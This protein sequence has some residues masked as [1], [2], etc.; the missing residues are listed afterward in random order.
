MSLQLDLALDAWNKGNAPD[1]ICHLTELFMQLEG[2]DHF[3]PLPMGIR[4]AD[5]ILE[6]IGLSLLPAGK[7][8]APKAL[9][10]DIIIATYLYA[11]G[12]HTALAGDLAATLSPPPMA[13]WLTMCHPWGVQGLQPGAIERTGLAKVTRSFDGSDPW[14]CAN[15]LVASIAELRPARIFLIHHPHDCAAVIAAA[16]AKAMGSS[17]LLLHHAD[18]RPTL[19]LYLSGIQIVD[20]TPR[21]AWFAKNIMGLSSS[22]IPLTCHDPGR[23][24]IDFLSSGSLTTGLCGND[25]KVSAMIH[26]AYPELIADILSV[27]RGIHVHVGQL[28]VRF[29]K[30]I[31][32]SLS[33]KNLEKERFVWVERTESLVEEMRR[34]RIDLMVNTYPGGGAR[35]AVEVMAAGIPMI[36]HSPF[37]ELD[38]LRAQMKYPSAHIWHTIEDLKG[39]LRRADKAWLERQGESARLWYEQQHHIGNWK[40]FFNGEGHLR[41][42]EIPGVFNA[43]A[44]MREVLEYTL[45]KKAESQSGR[46]ANP[47]VVNSF[48]TGVRRLCDI[49]LRKL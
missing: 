34:H 10:G 5:A 27:T 24:K 45:E 6:R 48:R 46:S 21:A 38:V 4:E 11:I 30:A 7:R 36:W 44:A 49:I 8:D 29:R 20:F 25:R 14:I 47:G 3:P 26:P 39:I 22:Y 17:I 19:G 9:E 43:S 2:L 31:A 16:A 40:A 37:A 1:V 18:S 23:T 33:A 15:Q 28:S 32:A 12:G 13:L 35:T 41:S 42:H